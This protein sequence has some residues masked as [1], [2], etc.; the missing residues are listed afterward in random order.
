MNTLFSEFQKI[1]FAEKKNED[2]LPLRIQ[3]NFK[4]NEIISA[5]YSK[6]GIF[7][8]ATKNKRLLRKCDEKYGIEDA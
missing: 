6:E 1:N 2:N 3:T 5:I 8:L 7:A 4:W